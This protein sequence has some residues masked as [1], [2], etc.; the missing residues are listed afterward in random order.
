MYKSQLSITDSSISKGT[1]P[2]DS[3][4]QQEMVPNS[5]PEYSLT[6][7]ALSVFVTQQY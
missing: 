3:V 6:R 2:L 5:N 4:V 7:Q 1:F